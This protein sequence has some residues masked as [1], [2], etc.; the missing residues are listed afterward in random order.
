MCQIFCCSIVQG[1]SFNYHQ[2]NVRSRVSVSNSQVSVSAFM[3]KSR[4]RNLSQVSVSEVTVSTTSLSFIFSKR[5]KPALKREMNSETFFTWLRSYYQIIIA[6]YMQYIYFVLV[7]Y[8]DTARNIDI[9]KCY[10]FQLGMPSS[11]PLIFFVW[12]PGMSKLLKSQA[13]SL[14]ETKS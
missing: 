3:T 10:I 8:W 1:V 11:L 9:H 13:V 12:S 14:P 2:R 7:K 6:C 4:S 5:I